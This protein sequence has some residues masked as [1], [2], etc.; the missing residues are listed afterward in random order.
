[1]SPCNLIA[2]LVNGSFYVL[3]VSRFCHNFEVLKLRITE[4]GS[5]PNPRLSFHVAC[6]LD[7]YP[8]QTVTLFAVAVVL[9][10]SVTNFAVLDCF[11][12]FIIVDYVA[13]CGCKVSGTVY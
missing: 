5:D 4:V 10:D 11:H 2:A 6:L 13:E 1:M 3:R 8:I 9:I 12:C 7:V